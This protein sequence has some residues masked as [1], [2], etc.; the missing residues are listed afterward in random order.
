[1]KHPVMKYAWPKDVF[2]FP[3]GLFII[4]AYKALWGLI[5]I[6]GGVLIVYSD[7]LIS[8]EL[9]EDP[10]DFVA[11]WLTN[12]I[13]ISH[14]DTV[15]IGLT[16]VAL[17]VIH[18]VLAACLWTRQYFIRSFGVVLFSIL[19]LYGLYHVIYYFS[20]LGMSA[21]AMDLISLVYFLLVLPQH[22]TKHLTYG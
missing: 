13:H 14:A 7:R 6:V 20:W 9:L 18:L 1:M 17:G 11:N 19:G 15:H 5:E 12:N 16:A 8:N 10:Q 22:L 21:L 3:L 4:I 2:G